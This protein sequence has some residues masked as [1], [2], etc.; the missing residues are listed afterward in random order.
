MKRILYYT[1]L[2]VVLASLPVPSVAVEKK[3]KEQPAKV[4][5]KPAPKAQPQ[6]QAIEKKD[7]PKQPKQGED[8]KYDKFVDA[9]NNGIDDRL[10]KD[11]KK[12]E[13]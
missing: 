9:N 6:G 7:Q 13:K 4:Q 3:Q 10:E 8:K 5:P 11:K 1:V 2:A 12:P